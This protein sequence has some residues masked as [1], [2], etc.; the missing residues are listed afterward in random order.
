METMSADD[1][2]VVNAMRRFGG[3][4]VY[5][6]S[7]A[8]ECADEINLAKIKAAW[9]EYWAAYKNMYD[10]AAKARRS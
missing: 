6:L 4:F 5:A 1:L 10:D 3:S 2:N 9:P 8:A 7:Q